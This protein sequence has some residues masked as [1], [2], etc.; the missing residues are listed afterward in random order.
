[1]HCILLCEL[2]VPCILV[3]VA[4]PRILLAMITVGNG[5]K[6]PADAIKSGLER[7][8]PN[9]FEID[10]LDFTAAVG[11][12]AFDKRHKDSWNWMLK[13]PSFAYW[14]QVIMDSIVPVKFTRFV[15]KKMLRQH[16]AHATTFIKEKQYALVVATHFFT[17][18]AIALAKDEF[19]LK[20]PLV[21][22]DA[23]P[24]DAH[25]MW[26]EPS[27]DEIIVASQQAKE[28]LIQK[29]MP[30]NKISVYNYPFATQ[31]TENLP[32]QA[33]A[34]AELNLENTMLTILQSAGGEGIGGQLEQSVESVFQANLP[35]QYIVICGRNTELLERLEGMAAR[36]PNSK[37]RFVVKGFIENMP[38]WIIAS[39]LILG[40]AG[41]A[42]T[43]E[44]LILGKP[45]FHVSY[46]AYNDRANMEWCVKQGVSEFIPK[47]EQLLEVL[48]RFLKHPEQL[49]MLHAR[50]RELNIQSGTLDIAKHLVERYLQ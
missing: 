34:R 5:H 42:S 1:M 28:K 45:I 17:I 35:V 43:M 46:V 21:G 26:V 10:V 38:T 41:A 31:F 9:Q 44:A 27:A 37:V 23:D 48:Q 11:D 25:A 40:K 16:A 29:T 32:S 12:L 33:A 4:K 2:I 19:D 50:V 47:P 24:F 20:I 7:L 49:T 13:Y 3:I 39:D 8:Y 22:F 30:A 6:A 15:Q 14:G 36:F 18:Q